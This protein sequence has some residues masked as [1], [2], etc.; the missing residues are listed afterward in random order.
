MS[1]TDHCPQLCKKPECG[2]PTD[3]PT[4]L[5][6]RCTDRPDRFKFN[7]NSK[8]RK[9][10]KF[11]RD[12]FAEAAYPDKCIRMSLTDHC[13][14]LCKKPECGFPTDSPTALAERCTDRPDRFKWNDNSKQRKWCKFVRDRF[15]EA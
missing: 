7:D 10:C 3:S 8:Q 14:Q 12:R 15:A 1:L 11:V 5:A 2:F 13:P 4:A 6:E 9:W